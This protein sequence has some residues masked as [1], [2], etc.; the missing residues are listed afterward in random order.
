MQWRVSSWPLNTRF[1]PGVQTFAFERALP[2]PRPPRSCASMEMGKS[3]S[4]FMVSTGWPWIM[5]PLLRKA[6]SGPP[7]V[8]SPRNRYSTAIT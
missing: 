7:L 5:I 6:Q 4:F 1:V 8:C 2:S 3:W